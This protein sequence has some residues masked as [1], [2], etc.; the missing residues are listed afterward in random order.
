M[1]GIEHTVDRVTNEIAG[2]D[3]TVTYTTNDGHLQNSR[4]YIGEAID[5]RTWG[6]TPQQ[7]RQY[8][9]SLQRNLGPDYRVI[10]EGNHIH[11]QTSGPRGR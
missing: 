4:H 9:N 11:V 8:R 5:L 10:E 7:V 1:T 6:M 3:A 2:R